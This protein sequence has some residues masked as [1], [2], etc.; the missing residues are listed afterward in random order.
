MFVEGYLSHTKVII[1]CSSNGSDGDL[2]IHISAC[3]N[4][5]EIQRNKQEPK[6]K[7][8]FV[9]AT[10]E[11]ERTYGPGSRALLSRWAGFV[12][13]FGLPWDVSVFLHH[14]TVPAGGIFE[15]HSASIATNVGSGASADRVAV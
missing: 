8:L 15:R 1:R 14:V 5:F 10:Y 7:D 6:S 3:H 11:C 2:K 9:R 4:T 12:F 13:L